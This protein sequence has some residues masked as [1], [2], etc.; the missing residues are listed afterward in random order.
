MKPFPPTLY[1][2]FPSICLGGGKY[3]ITIYLF[4]PSRQVLTQTVNLSYYPSGRRRRALSVFLDHDRAR[5]SEV[6]ISVSTVRRVN[7]AYKDIGS[8]DCDQKPFVRQTFKPCHIR[9][10]SREHEVMGH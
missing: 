3:V 6:H 7:S 9:M 10:Q 5:T 8:L 4:N 2:F 1:D